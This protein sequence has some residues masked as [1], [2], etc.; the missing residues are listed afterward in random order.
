VKHL[1]IFP[2]VFLL[3]FS[4]FAQK[5]QKDS[6]DQALKK[7]EFEDYEGALEDLDK[8]VESDSL[9]AVVFYKR[10]YVNA[11]L[12]KHQEAL[13]DFDR[14][15]QLSPGEA[16]YY[17]E[18]GVAKLNL[19]DKSGACQDWKKAA[20]MGSEVARELAYEYCP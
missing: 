19:D 17:S 18:R 20:S 12:L 11:M 10:G 7:I 16:E 15:I 8:A 2:A 14:A 3:T 9:N 1:L 6:Y 4:A 13:T 5:K